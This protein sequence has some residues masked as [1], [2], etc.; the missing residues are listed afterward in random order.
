MG[1]EI[2]DPRLYIHYG[3][4]DTKYLTDQ[5]AHRSRAIWDNNSE[6]LILVIHKGTTNLPAWHDRLTPYI[7]RTGLG[8]LRHFMRIKSTTICLRQCRSDGAPKPIR[9]TFRRGK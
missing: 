2:Y 3:P 6:S 1:A 8:M 9:S 4:R 5:E 7:E